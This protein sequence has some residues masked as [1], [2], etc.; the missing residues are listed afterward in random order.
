[1][2]DLSQLNKFICTLVLKISFRKNTLKNVSGYVNSHRFL[3]DKYK[4]L[5]WMYTRPREI[6]K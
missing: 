6:F 1:M 5:I 2:S 4:I 3:R